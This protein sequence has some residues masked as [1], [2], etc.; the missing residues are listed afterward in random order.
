MAGKSELWYYTVHEKAFLS[1][2]LLKF[3]YSEKATNFFEIS[4]VDLSYVVTVK[5]TVEISQNF[6][7]FSEYMNFYQEFLAKFLSEKQI[8]KTFSISDQ[9]SPRNFQKLI[10]NFWAKFLSEKQMASANGKHLCCRSEFSNS[11]SRI[12]TGVPV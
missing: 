1:M 9:N 2:L 12:S 7:A 11:S 10:K 8:R 6:V 4:T 5:S 3:I